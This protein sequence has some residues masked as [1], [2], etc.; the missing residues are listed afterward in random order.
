[1]VFNLLVYEECL[2]NHH[3]IV[4]MIKVVYS[5]DRHSSVSKTV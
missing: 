5:S 4:S 1:M 3:T 2:T